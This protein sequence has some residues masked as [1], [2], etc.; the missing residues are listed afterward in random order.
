LFAEDAGVRT[1]TI[2]TGFLAISAM[3]L[4]SDCPLLQPSLASA[5]QSI[6]ESVP[7]KAAV[8]RAHPL[9]QNRRRGNRHRLQIPATLLLEGDKPHEIPVTVTEMSVAGIGLHA[10]QEV[11]IGATYRV[12]SFDTLIPHGLRACIVTQR[13]LPDGKF[14]IGAKTI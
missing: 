1:R 5:D 8:K 10:T 3:G 14:E 4:I 2:G 7:A 11:V 13:H 12:S 9:A 6:M